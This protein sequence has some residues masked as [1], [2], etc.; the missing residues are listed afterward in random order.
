[1]NIT[2]TMVTRVNFML[3]IFYHSNKKKKLVG[4]EPWPHILL[5]SPLPKLLTNAGS[6]ALW[7]CLGTGTSKEVQ[8]RPLHPLNIHPCTQVPFVLPPDT[9]SEVREATPSNT[10]KQ[11]GLVWQWLL[12]SNLGPSSPPW[13]SGPGKSRLCFQKKGHTKKSTHDSNFHLWVEQGLNVNKLSTYWLMSGNASM[14]Q[15]TKRSTRSRNSG[16]TPS[17]DWKS[18]R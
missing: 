3:Y 15:Q 1:M 11:P 16:L 12:N 18:Q 10:A 9:W 6:A 14:N 17:V 4:P 7:P 2:K 8:L 5:P 13:L